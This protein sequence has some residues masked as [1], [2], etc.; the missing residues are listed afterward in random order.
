MIEQSIIFMLNSIMRPL[1]LNK[2]ILKIE[3]S[4]SNLN[5]C[6]TQHSCL[7]K[8]NVSNFF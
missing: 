6:Q 7:R 1:L 5:L 4:N 2:T 8:G 3:L